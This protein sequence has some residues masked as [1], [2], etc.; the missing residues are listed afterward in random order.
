MLFARFIFRYFVVVFSIFIQGCAVNLDARGNMSLGL[1]EAELFGR[2]IT[3]FSLPDGG[4]GALRVL[5][6]E[7]SLKIDQFSRVIPIGQ[8]KTARIVNVEQVNDRTTI[9]VETADRYCDYKYYLYSIKAGDVL[10]WDFNGDCR[11]PVTVQKSSNEQ[12]FDFRGNYLVTRYT[13]RDSRLFRSDIPISRLPQIEPIEP[14]NNASPKST[15]PVATTT[16]SKA[17]TTISDTVK[18]T[19]VGTKAAPVARAS[20]SAPMPSKLEFPAEEKKAVRIVLDK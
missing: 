15:P 10:S 17:S 1:D 4:T 16:T 12:L 2:K 18:N 14:P 5:G 6:N 13:Y 20:K 3:S 7:Y 8:A 9:L 11:T 19:S